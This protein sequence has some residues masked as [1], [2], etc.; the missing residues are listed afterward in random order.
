M[1]KRI[2]SIMGILAMLVVLI[3]SGVS[4]SAALPDYKP[5]DVGPE[6]RT[7]E[8][9]PERI[10]PKT[11]EEQALAATA[12]APEDYPCYV[13]TK[14][15]MSLDD[16]TGFY[17]FTDF[18]LIA[19]TA[20][21]EL[22][23]QSDLSYPEGDPRDLP[24]VTCEQAAYLLSEFDGNMYPTETSFFGTPDFHDGTNS[25]LEAL[26][27]EPAGY[28]ANEAGRQVV[29][30]SNF[31]DEAYYDPTYPNYIAGFYSPSFEEYFDRNIMSI[32][33][34]DWLNRVGPDGSRPYLYESVFAHE[35]QHLLHD[36]YDSDEITWMNESLSMFSEYLTG[37]VVNEDNYTTFQEMPENSLTAWGDQGGE[38]I[39]ADYGM[40]FLYQMYLYEKFGKEFIQAEFH[41]PDNGITSVNS[42][43]AS[44]KKW[45]KSSFAETYHD[46]SVA[47]LVDSSQNNYK[48]GFKK[49]NVGID[50]GTP[51]APN[52][53]AFDT[54]GAPPWG[55]DYI[56]LTGS[57][58][59]FG[60]LLFN[61]VDISKSP[62]AWTSVNG[63]LYSGTGDEV[64]NWAIFETAGGGVLSIDTT[65]NLEDYWDFAFVQVST[66]G[67]VHWTSLAD[68]EGYSTTDYDPNAY[69]TVIENV[70]GLT[71][72][73]PTP[74]TL[75]YDLSPFAGQNILVA[76]RLV[77]DWGTHY[78]GWYVDN[79][80][81]DGNLISD[82]T[83]ASIFK[84]IS[85]LFPVD[86]NFT[87]TFVGKKGFGKWSQYQVHTMRL[88]KVTEQGMIDLRK[89]MGWSDKAVMIVTFDAP[90]GYN[91]YADYTYEVVNKWDHGKKVD[92]RKTHS[93]PHHNH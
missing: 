84:D 88:D 22:W 87:V 29:L 67:G 62:T 90:E 45:K 19:E 64:D 83:D 14:E 20:T 13:E 70:P 35:Y 85:E 47:V 7:W 52:L 56:W 71:G 54:A 12:L 17:F 61:G 3:P 44:N 92:Y 30:V 48:Y 28:Y 6:L 80:Y 79:V 25:L 58:K 91:N 51:D 57:P 78:E 27:Y 33:S 32:D 60:K 93:S 40:A 75:T 76:F 59:K 41:N 34:H 37:Y 74:V 50:I 69:P 16:T 36:D 39:V 26:G 11:D 24:V 53:E 18:Y 63:M 81:V 89:V 42:T 86:N 21:S 46:F 4:A 72:Y 10:A 82:G 23:V 77:T 73:N 43:M 66:D 31:I 1:K 65:W 55:A 68:N 9:T 8:A 49:L 5:V 2:I 15:W 38:E